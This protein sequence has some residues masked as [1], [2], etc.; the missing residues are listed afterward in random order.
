MPRL[1]RIVI[2]D[3]PHH[4]TQRGN[5]RQNVFFSDADRKQ[6]LNWLKQYSARYDLLV[7]GYCLMT[8][9]VHIVATPRKADSLARTL[10]IVHMRHSQSVNK[11]QGWS[12]H[13]WQGRFFS[14]AL[15]EKHLWLCMRYVEQN[16]VRAGIVAYAEDYIWS[17]A[18]F[19]CGLRDD[20]VV[21]HG[22]R[23]GGALEDWRTI[24]KEMP[25]KEDIELIQRR[26][27]SGIPCG[28]KRFLSRM[29][30]KAG[31]EYFERKQGR[32]R[33]QV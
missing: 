12:G 4:I 25:L 15:D 22:Y 29:S 19:H 33:K 10:N 31:V 14:T 3:V 9:H 1:P 2:T 5:R 7:H 27:H 32:P 20:D 30:R 6:Y 17:S 18:A 23:F 21:P 8:N 28:D 24:L 26:T 16:P 13:L 11:T